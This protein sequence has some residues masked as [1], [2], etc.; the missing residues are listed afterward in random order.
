VN[1]RYYTEKKARELGVVG[2][3]RNCLDGS[4]EVL[5]EGEE[6]ALN[7]LKAWLHHG[8]PSAEV[9]SVEASW[10]EPSGEFTTFKTAY[11]VE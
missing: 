1:F 8:S 5:A 10:E 11:F 7:S 4:V 6:A 3:V 9:D 2:W